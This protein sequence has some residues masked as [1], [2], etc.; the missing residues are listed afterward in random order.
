MKLD[1]QPYPGSHRLAHGSDDSD[2]ELALLGRQVLPGGAKRVELETA[3][4]PCDCV[5][6]PLGVLRGGT[7][8]AVPPV[9]VGRDTP[10]VAP[11]KQPVDGLVASLTYDVPERDLD[12]ADRRHHRAAALVLVAYHGADDGLDVERVAAKHPV[13]D[14]FVDDGLDRLLLP[15]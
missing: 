10:V 2:R 1:H 15:L 7:R 14:P 5:P 3:V 6:R 9:G 11:A 8:A 12:A 13:L 4:A